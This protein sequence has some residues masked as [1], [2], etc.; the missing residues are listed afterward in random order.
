[1]HRA[2]ALPAINVNS[3]AFGEVDE[4]IVPKPMK[5]SENLSAIRSH[6]YMRCTEAKT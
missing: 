3:N 5:G 6:R 4:A 2:T 1:M